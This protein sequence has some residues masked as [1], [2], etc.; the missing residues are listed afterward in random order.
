MNYFFLVGHP[1]SYLYAKAI[2]KI[3]KQGSREQIHCHAIINPH[4]YQEI[5]NVDCRNGFDDY[6]EIVNCDFNKN[7]LKGIGLFLLFKKSLRELKF[8]SGDLM[9]A[10]Q[11]M[12]F[13][14]QFLMKMARRA[15]VRVVLIDKPSVGVV[16]KTGWLHTLIN[17]IYSLITQVPLMRTILTDNGEF[18][19]RIPVFGT[20]DLKVTLVESRD[21]AKNFSSMLLPEPSAVLRNDCLSSQRE[22]VVILTDATLHVAYPEINHEKMNLKLNEIVN[23]IRD[24]YSDCTLL[25]KPHPLD[26]NL[27][28]RGVDIRG[29]LKIA[30]CLAEEF[31]LE[32]FSKIVAIYTICSTAIKS[33]SLI[34]IP[35]YTLYRLVIEDEKVRGRIDSMF[36]G[37]SDSLCYCAVNEITQI[38]SIDSEK[39]QD[40]LSEIYVSW[41]LF[42]DHLIENR[43]NFKPQ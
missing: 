34:G 16:G 14:L 40:E 2:A 27:A 33:S 9:F 41:N 10:Y 25:Y 8:K 4:P 31:F 39:R 32:N 22:M 19:S 43:S 30:P 12:E 24:V 20:N 5:L 38:G 21:N 15:G 42:L 3:A 1:G 23:K 13:P 6:T 18:L 26:M 37:Y 11:T 28:P 36:A 29:F 7:I 17:L 35:S